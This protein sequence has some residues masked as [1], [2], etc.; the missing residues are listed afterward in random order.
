MTQ[1]S[2]PYRL[3]RTART[4]MICDDV[5]LTYEPVLLYFHAEYIF[6]LN[7]DIDS[8][9]SNNSVGFIQNNQSQNNR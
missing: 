5:D 1:R 6:A 9:R 7:R 3:R 4:L 8:K 2:S